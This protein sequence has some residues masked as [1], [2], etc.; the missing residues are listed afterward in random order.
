VKQRHF[1]VTSAGS[2]R[3]YKKWSCRNDWSK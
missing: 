2:V 1:A 3:D